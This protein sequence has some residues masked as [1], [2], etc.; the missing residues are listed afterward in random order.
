M[1]THIMPLAADIQTDGGAI[2][3]AVVWIDSLLLGSIGSSFAIIAVA[4]VGFRI[5]SGE[6]PI[7][8]GLRVIVGVFI[9]F[10]SPFLARSLL[11][12]ARP[13]GGVAVIPLEIAVP[14]PVLTPRAPAAPTPF[15]PYAGAS[16]Y[17]LY[18]GI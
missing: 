14:P 1:G 3:G 6:L 8:H 4:F 13:N 11:D 7:R 17:Q 18:R 2:N 10:G 5:L 16:A 12:L 15:D 9:L